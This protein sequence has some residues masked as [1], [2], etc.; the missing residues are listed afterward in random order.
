MKTNVLLIAFL[1]FVG[2]ERE[3]SKP[4]LNTHWKLAS[5]ESTTTKAITNYPDNLRNEIVIFTDSLNTV[6]VNGVCNGCIG[7]YSIIND[8]ILYYSLGCTMIYCSPWEDY[9]FHNLDSM[10]LYRVKE[11]Q[12]IIYS[13]GTYN[14]YFEAK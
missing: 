12:L 8:S 14:L 6:R 11:S 1:I 3:Q 13:R 5:I 10:F 7:L 2:C 4:L 9:L